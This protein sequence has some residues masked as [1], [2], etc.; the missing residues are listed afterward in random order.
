MKQITKFQEPNS[1][2]QHRAQQFAHFDNIPNVT[3]EELK[4]NLLSEQGHICCYCMRRIPEKS[5]PYMKVEHFKCQDHFQDLQLDYKNLLGACTGNEGHPKKLQTCDTQKANE[6]L[7]INPLN[8]NPSCETLFKFNSE[9]EM[10]SIS[11]DETIDKQINA[12]LNLNMQSLKDARKEVYYVVQ[13]RVRAESK[14]T[15]KDKPAF[16]RFLNQELQM[17]QSK[18]DGKFRPY[19]L[20]AIYYLT[21]KLRSN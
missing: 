20:V 11:D 9:G 4:Q 16:L 18:T 2:L 21:K 5:S 12:I 13:E 17:W 15:K 14:R 1:L 3:K 19:C 8:T 6:A 7:T 10:S